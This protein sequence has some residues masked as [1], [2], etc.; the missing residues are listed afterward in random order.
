MEKSQVIQA[1][2]HE[3]SN[4]LVPP[5]VEAAS[6]RVVPETEQGVELLRAR[7]ALW[8]G[9][10]AALAT[11]YDVSANVVGVWAL[12]RRWSDQVAHPGNWAV[13]AEVVAFVA[14][15]L[16]VTRGRPSL[17]QLRA[18]DVALIAILS[19]VGAYLSYLCPGAVHPGLDLGAP[20]SA[21]L[22]IGV[23]SNIAMLCMRAALI[24]STPRRT[25]LIGAISTLPVLVSGYLVYREY[26]S[27]DAIN[28]ALG[29]TLVSLVVIP[30]PVLISRMIYDLRRQ[31]EAA[32]QLGQY[33]LEAKIGEGGMGIVYRANH[34]LLRRPTAIK[35]LPTH[36]VGAVSLARFEREVLE[37]SR[38]SHPNTVAIFD[39]GRTAEGV[40]Y[41]AMEY[42]EGLS[43]EQLVEHEGPQPEG[44]VV[45]LVRQVCG[46]L[47]E[48]HRRGLVHRDVKPANLHLCVRGDVPD[49]V[50]V[51]DFGLAKQLETKDPKLSTAGAVLGTP[52]YM[53][54]E[55][56]ASADSIDARADIYALGAVT[57]FL[58]TGSP[59]FRGDSPLAVFAQTLHQPPEPPSKR[60]G[61]AVSRELEQLILRCLSKAPEQRPD[62]AAELAELL[63]AVGGVAPWSEADARRW[64]QE[65]SELV[66]EQ[67][68]L[69]RRDASSS[70]ER[71]VAVDLER[72]RRG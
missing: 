25:L 71:T 6:I 46:A 18:I 53:A 8:L 65:R 15:Y 21:N 32:E 31:V 10:T 23:I 58:L 17:R 51:L 38:L 54:P 43:F 11:S 69:A 35:L 52:L 2:E 16:W 37:T 14:L 30:I 48:A 67:I 47:S 42:L 63:A 70:G 59:P 33:T 36:R 22:P 45:H 13:A 5:A 60:L 40:F 50:K 29:T 27:E 1:T 9:V 39:Y 61:K 4:S 64:W 28:F 55:V 24:P 12:G 57:Y 68:E 7:L 44:R 72:R 34:A 26:L 20:P 62:S 56:V 49:F 19:L 41:Y 3:A 66:L